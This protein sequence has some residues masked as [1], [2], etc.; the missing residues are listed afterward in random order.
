MIERYSFKQA[1]DILNPAD[2]PSGLN[3]KEQRKI[4][5]W[6]ILRKKRFYKFV[7]FVKNGEGIWT[8]YDKATKYNQW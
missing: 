8:S 4:F 7:S 5:W 1:R 2:Y 3:R 6:A